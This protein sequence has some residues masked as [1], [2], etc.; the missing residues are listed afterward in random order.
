MT[1]PMRVT[2]FTPSLEQGGTERQ[3]SE[4]LTRFDRA[5]VEA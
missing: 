2:L 5:R 1:R 4:L 3:L